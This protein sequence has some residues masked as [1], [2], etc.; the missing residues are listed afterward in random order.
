MA[1]TKTTAPISETSE[2]HRKIPKA[3]FVENVEAWVEKYTDDGL[4]A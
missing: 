3:V 2:L 4:F 1:E